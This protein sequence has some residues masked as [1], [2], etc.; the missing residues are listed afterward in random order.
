MTLADVSLIVTAGFRPG[1]LNNFLLG[2]KKFIPE[3]K[4]IVVNDDNYPSYYQQNLPPNT[5]WEQVPYDTFLTRKRNLAVQLIDTKYAVLMADDFLINSDARRTLIKMLNI[6][7]MYSQPDIIAGTFNDRPYEGYLEIRDGEYIREIPLDVKTAVPFSLFK[8]YYIK[9]LYQVDIAA[10]FFMARTKLLR[11]VPWDETIGPIGGEHADWFL[12]VKAAGG[13]VVWTY[14]L[15][16]YEQ[17][18]N[19]D[20][21]S[22]DY[23]RMRHRVWEGH[24]LFLAKRGVKRYIQFGEQP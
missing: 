5:I 13:V 10:N 12:D 17:P 11:Q 22:P 2:A 18:K 24:K 15:N 21:E 16:I 3:A 8:N 4:I 14:G 19:L 1:Y 7:D 20:M 6:L 23:G 9:N